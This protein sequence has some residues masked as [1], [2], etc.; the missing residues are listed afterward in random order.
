MKRACVIGDPIAHS[1]SPLVHGF[2]LTEL[3][4]AGVYER[5]HVVAAE[6]AGFLRGL[7]AHGYVGCNVTLPHKEAAF[8]LVDET[9]ELARALE[10]VNTIWLDERGRLH[11]DNTDVHGFLAN[12]DH[13]APGWR[14]STRTALILGAGGSTRAILAALSSCGVERILIA[15]RTLER[16]AALVAGQAR[17]IEIMTLDRLPEMLPDID[18]LINTTSLGMVGQPDHGFEIDRLKAD[19]LVTDIVYVPLE[20]PLLREARRMG[21]KTVGGLGMLLH[22]AVPGFEHWFGRRP[23]VTEALYRRV[24][25]DIAT[26]HS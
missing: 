21:R 24:A 2:W 7:A 10:A 4:I 19:A 25:A 23:L 18:L 16:A 26:G 11:G 9:T 22:Q 15:N 6:L 3:G 8:R 17:R 12:L 1:R 5:R 13:E 20:T 14:A